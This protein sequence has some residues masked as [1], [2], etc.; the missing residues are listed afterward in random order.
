MQA[1]VSEVR[2]KP[3]LKALRVVFDLHLDIAPLGTVV[4]CLLASI[5][6]SSFSITLQCICG[7]VLSLCCFQWISSECILVWVQLNLT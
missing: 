7:G 2:A 6:T 5:Q 4:T 1:K 3:R